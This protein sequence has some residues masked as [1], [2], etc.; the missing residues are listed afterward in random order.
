[1]PQF[2]PPNLQLKSKEEAFAQGITP[3]IQTLPALMRE[4][5]LQRQ[6]TDLEGQTLKR[7][8]A[9]KN[10]QQQIELLKLGRGQAVYNPETKTSETFPGVTG[11]RIDF[12]N[13]GLPSLV[14]EGGEPTVG[15]DGITVPAVP[16][17]PGISG[18]K[19]TPTPRAPVDE[20]AKLEA[21]NRAKLNAEK[22]KALGS[23][24]N[25]LR[26]FDNM[27]KAA[28]SIKDDEAL[29][30]S[31][32]LAAGRMK[33]SEGQRRVDANLET[34]KA[35][36]LLNVLASMKELSKTG[37]SGFGQLSEIEGENLRNSISSLIRTQGTEDFKKSLDRFIAE[38]EAKKIDLQDTFATIYGDIG[39]APG[40]SVAPSADSG[41][42]KIISVE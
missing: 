9:Y 32:G 20:G 19:V 24:K 38:M 12:D 10:V 8:Q 26:E 2:N 29:P 27:I 3:A 21:R 14:K 34:L 37:A 36:T 5:R 17:S 6:K 41:K 42:F 1:M 28:Q 23:F 40:S 39:N 31:T 7:D 16:A 11:Y 25:T 22:P 18:V 13:D 15:P 4:Y 35:K 30:S 33:L